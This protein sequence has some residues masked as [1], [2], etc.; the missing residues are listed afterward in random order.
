MRGAVAAMPLIVA[1][2]CD[3]VAQAIA[4]GDGGS[5]AADT[6]GGSSDGDRTET[7]RDGDGVEASLDCNDHHALVYPDAPEVFDGFDNDCDGSID[8]DGAN[9]PMFAGYGSG[10][11]GGAGGAVVRV[12]TLA[13]TGPGSLR[14]AIA[15]ATGSTIIEF[16][17]GGEIVLESELRLRP[18][19]TIHGASAPAPGITLR[20][21][22]PDVR[23]LIPG[24][25]EVIITHLRLLG[26]HEPGSE[27]SALTPAL[28][29]DG[30]TAPDNEVRQIVLDHLTLSRTTGGGPDVWGEARDIT[31]SYCLV[32]EA[33]SGTTVSY[34]GA[35]FTEQ[36][37]SLHHN[38]WV[39]NQRHSPQLRGQVRDLD[40]VNNIVVNWGGV[41]SEDAMGLWVRAEANEASVDANIIANHYAS[42]RRPEW[43]L[44]YGDVPGPMDA[45]GGPP[46]P[47]AQGDVV[48][49]PGLGALW[50]A[51]NRLPP[52][53]VDRFSTVDAPLDV[54][55]AAAVPR[56]PAEELALAT[57][58]WAGAHHTTPAEQAHK[59][60]AAASF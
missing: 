32:V 31:I 6:D 47:A 30:D 29:V 53:T 19:M 41:A 40:F 54:P 56:W 60:T 57:L 2:G 3:G 15:G 59:D 39:D 45:G 52:E 9:T 48:A 17:V 10:A 38:V 28:I 20:A 22:A 44:V 24:T 18:F 36:R 13:D 34:I 26:T 25:Q 42:Q 43:A 50:V 35:G 16:D 1:L 8:E 14:E 27:P 7:D 11:V 5:G 55:D 21:A 33:W 12:T 37:I 58:P 46:T 51:D 49:A 23:V 4:T